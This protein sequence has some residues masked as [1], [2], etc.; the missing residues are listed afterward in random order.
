LAHA[1][2][3]PQY[4]Y[5][6]NGNRL[7]MTDPVGT[8][9]Y[10]YDALNRVT[11]ITNPK[12]E[13]ITYTYD[14]V[15]RRTS[16][17]LPNGIVTTYTYDATGRLTSLVHKLNGSII[18]SFT[19][20]YD[21]AGNRI[22]M[23]D[24]HGT[25]TYTYDAKY[26]LTQAVHPNQP[27]ETYGY[28]PVG[29]RLGGTYDAANR[30]LE[31][32]NFI[33]SYDGG[34]NTTQKVDKTTGEV[35]KYY[36]N[37]ENQLV[38]LEKYHAAADHTP[39][40]TVNYIYDGQGRRVAKNVDGAI[41]KYVYDGEDILLE[42]DENDNIIARYMHGPTIDEPLIL[43]RNGQ[44]Y[45]Y[46][47]DGLGSVVKL[48]DS[49]GNVVNSYVYDSFGNMVQKTENVVNPYT[50]TA[51]E[52]DVESGSYYH[53]HRY[54]DPKTG[55]FIAPDPV[56][57][58]T[59]MLL[60][61][62]SPPDMQD[63]PLTNLLYQKYLRNP[64]LSNGYI[65]A[66]NNPVNIIDP[67]GLQAIALSAPVAYPIIL[68][69]VNPYVLIGGTALAICYATPKCRRYINCAIQFI[70]DFAKCAGRGLCPG[71]DPAETEKCIRRA[72][73]KFKRC[74]KGFRVI[75]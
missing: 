50:Y 19:Y 13:V 27:T 22:T 66:L 24:E 49:A 45:Y 34:G 47:T 12:G 69:Y 74:T 4:T 62:G 39:Y 26:Q 75:K 54:Y 32:D 2:L 53:R 30:L 3:D 18:A 40:S 10:E 8:T 9:T 37:A 7:T 25:H 57:L 60:K 28:D 70:I 21:A 65:Y 31:D 55:R 58:S 29:N 61:R 46:L 72:W 16:T 42:T 11:R 51:R 41:T 44:S 43:E 67:Y 6:L 36:W 23:T 14:A 63:D 48:V 73:R 20:T 1:N 35:V 52:Y 56:N 71:A 38:K 17:T 33:Y 15:G 68:P 64:L 59:I 5:D